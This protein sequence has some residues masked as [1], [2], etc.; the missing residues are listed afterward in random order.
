[1]SLLE[2]VGLSSVFFVPVSRLLAGDDDIDLP[3]GSTMPLKRVRA[4]LAGEGEVVIR[5][6]SDDEQREYAARHDDMRKIAKRVGASVEEVDAAAYRVFGQSL[7]A[8]RDER[9]GD[10]SDLPARSAQTKRGHVT[11]KMVEE[12]RAYFRDRGGDDG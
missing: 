10:L 12:L 5:D 6:L 8:E 3:D 4:A 1:M 2:V 7:F 11:R 9:A